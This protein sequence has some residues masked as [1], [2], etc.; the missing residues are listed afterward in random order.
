M[1]FGVEHGDAL[2]DVIERRLQ[3]LA[4]EMQR[5][6]GVVEQFQRRLG[7]HSALAQQERQHEA[8][9][10]RAD[11]RRDQMFGV[12]KQQKIRGR[13]A[14]EIDA[15]GG[16][17]GLERLQR[18]VGSEI[19]R[20]RAE[21]IL[22]CHRGAP[23]PEIRS[24][25]CQLVGHEQVG[26]HPL[27]RCGLADQR[28]HDVSQQVERQAPE[29]TVNQRSHF[30]A[31]QRLRPKGGDPEQ[32]FLE[33]YRAARIDIG[34]TRQEQRIGP[35]GEA[36]QHAAHGAARRGATPEQSAEKR[37]RELCDGRE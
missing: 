25:G 13:A 3:H 1:E 33:P 19:L 37:R 8:G 20:H 24:N 2:A 6:V 23:A 17:E 28:Q 30:G 7:G 36:D 27:D 12:A 10:R 32:A 35:D 21:Q 4:I 5:G 31:E 9:R 16:C 22:H 14:V 34:K 18:A 15:M 26:L 11:R 29:Y